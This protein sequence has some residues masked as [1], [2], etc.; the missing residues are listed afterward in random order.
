MQSDNIEPLLN[1]SLKAILT[2][3]IAFIIIFSVNYI[4]FIIIN[5]NNKSGTK[6]KRINILPRKPTRNLI[7]NM[8]MISNTIKE[9]VINE[10]I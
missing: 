10:N 3:L 1:K 7:P 4:S 2:L 5:N 6:N 8:G 9:K